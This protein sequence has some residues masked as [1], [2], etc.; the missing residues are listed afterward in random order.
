MRATFL[1]GL[2]VFFAGLV[3]G[4][5]IHA[6]SGAARQPAPW[7]GDF[8]TGNLSQWRG[9][10]VKAPSRVTI[11][12]EIVRQGHA[13]ARFEVRS[14]DS[15]V[16]G[17]GSGER[18]EVLIST[19]TTEGFEGREQYWAWSTYFPADFDA[20]KGSWNA[21]TQFH[22]VGGLGQVNIHFAVSKMKTLTLRVIGGSLSRPLRRDFVLAP[23]KRGRWY[24]FVFHVKWSSSSRAGFVEVWVNRSRVVRRTAT[25]TLYA[26][27]DVYL[28]QGYYRQ[29]H[30]G[31]TVVYHDGTRRG[32]TLADV[33]DWGLKRE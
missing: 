31:T 15:N 24:D 28:K 13:A 8:E 25:P 32:S 1:V 14:G 26:G 16:A 19:S 4:G 9:L 21:F 33:V 12:T 7:S 18:A 20:P 30:K 2:S 10:Q 11:Q 29:A 6:A 23:L 5:A 3:S 22:H 17:S 27:K